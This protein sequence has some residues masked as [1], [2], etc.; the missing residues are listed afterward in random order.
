MENYAEFISKTN[1]E[2]ASHGQRNPKDKNI[3]FQLQQYS[4][5]QTSSEMHRPAFSAL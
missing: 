3:V 2:V 5:T 1:E 4:P